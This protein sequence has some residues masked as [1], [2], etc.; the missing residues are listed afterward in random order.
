[1]NCIGPTARSCSSRRRAG[2]RRCPEP[3]HTGPEPSSAHS[4][5]RLGQAAV[6]PHLAAGDPAVVGLHPPDPGQRRPGQPAIRVARA[7]RSARRPRRRAAPW[8]ARPA[9]GAV[10]SA[11][12]CSPSSV[13]PPGSGATCRHRGARRHVGRTDR[14][15]GCGR[16]RR[17]AAPRTTQPI[18]VNTR[19]ARAAATTGRRGP[20]PGRSRRGVPGHRSGQ[21][22]CG[23][24][25]GGRSAHAVRSSGQV[26]CSAGAADRGQNRRQASASR[27][28]GSAPAAARGVLGGAQVV[29]EAP[30]RRAQLGLRVDAGQLARRR[31]ART[32]GRPARLPSGSRSAGQPARRARET[33]LA[34]QRHRR[35]GQRHPVHTGLALLLGALQLLPAVLLVGRASPPARCRR[36]RAGAGRPASPP[37]RRPRRRSSKPAVRVLGGDPGVEEHLQ[38]H[39]AELLAQRAPRSSSSIAWYSS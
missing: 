1:M 28:C 36:R 9:G 38:Q 19:P 18:T 16:L 21:P 27:A 14:A 20:G 15:A 35:L 26:T 39:V 34:G 11:H 13:S 10:C 31:P 5:D 33:S 12:R 3:R 6:G 8:P 30:R 4:D 22:R 25:R 23:W 29:G 32:A 17:S 2:R 24:H 37:G 7:G